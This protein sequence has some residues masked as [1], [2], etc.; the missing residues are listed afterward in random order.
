MA[1]KAIVW[2]GGQRASSSLTHQE[3]SAS[4]SLLN[5]SKFVYL[6]LSFRVRHCVT[7]RL[8]YMQSTPSP[9]AVDDPNPLIDSRLGKHKGYV[10]VS[11]LFENTHDQ[12]LRPSSIGK[13]EKASWETVLSDRP[14]RPHRWGS[15]ISRQRVD[16]SE[17]V[18]LPPGI[19]SPL[20]D[21]MR[22]VEAEDQVGLEQFLPL[23]VFFF[24]R[25]AAGGS[26][27]EIVFLKY[28]GIFH[29]IDRSPLLLPLQFIFSKAY[30]MLPSLIAARRG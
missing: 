14:A 9:Y 3:I 7:E 4:H 1:D 29:L 27:L 17:V 18:G 15:L 5:T 26:F 2:H 10:S 12:T 8:T 30:T 24:P 11:S 23:Q 16:V 20:Q 25:R 22:T 21:R 6:P 28:L 13:A 19:G